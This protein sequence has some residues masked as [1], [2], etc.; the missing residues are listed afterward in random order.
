MCLGRG[1][2]EWDWLNMSPACDPRYLPQDDPEVLELVYLVGCLYA[3]Q[4][5]II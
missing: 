4:F 1:N 3:L 5:S 2:D